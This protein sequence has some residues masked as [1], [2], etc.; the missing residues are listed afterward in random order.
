M[1]LF[2]ALI[3]PGLL[4]LAEREIS[5]KRTPFRGR[6][7]AIFALTGMFLLWCLRYAEHAKAEGLVLNNPI[8]TVPVDRVAAEPYPVEP[9]SLARDCRDREL[10]SV[11][12]GQ[13]PH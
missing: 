10:L 1:L 4:G 12:R 7:W 11:R 3:I 13:Q 2:A 6:N 9:V 5:S 8:T